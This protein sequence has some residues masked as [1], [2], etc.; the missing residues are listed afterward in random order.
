MES[1]VFQWDK[2]G[3]LFRPSGQHGWMNSHAQV[4]TV[5]PRPA[6]GIVRVYFS[7]RPKP[8]LS[9][10]TYVDL[11]ASDLKR[12]V[13]LHPE[14]LLPLGGQGM[15]DEHGLM[16]SSVVEHEGAV[17][18]YYSGWSRGTTLPYANF[19][20]LA[21]S[22]DG[23]RTFA[24]IGPGPVLDRTPWGPYSATSPHVFIHDGQWYMFYCSGVAWVEVEGKLEHTYDLKL[25]RSHDGI[26]WEQTGEVIVPQSRPNEAITKPAVLVENGRFHLWFCSRSSESFRGGEGSYRIG[27]AFS[28][29]LVHW[30]RDDSLAGI[31]PGP[32]EWDS[33]MLAYPDIATI[34]GETWLFYNGNH[35][36][37]G[38]FGAARRLL[39]S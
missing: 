36:G 27:Y 34:N 22:E 13:H 25:A 14:P 15:F 19:T 6:E 21:I 2:Q 9:L 10:T 17:Y 31:G 5:F 20:G 35:F 24:K 30:E 33:E 37:R 32:E 3:L 28:E 8:D 4:P 7:T 38:G 39:P 1:T 16:P 11:D 12:E 26:R 29:D 18:L 23:G